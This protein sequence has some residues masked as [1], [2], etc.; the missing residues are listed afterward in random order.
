MELIGENKVDWSNNESV[1]EF[2]EKNMLYFS[3]YNL[4]ADI[5]LIVD[6]LN[7]KLAYS[8]ALL[9]KHRYTKTLPILEHIQELLQKI[10]DTDYYE[11]INENYLFYKGMTY[12]RLKN[13]KESQKCF[14]LLVNID[15]ENE[16]YKRWYLSNKNA[17]F[18]SKFTIIGYIGL[19]IIFLDLILSFGFHVRLYP[20]VVL[21]GIIM[22]LGLLMGN[23]KN[24][25]DKVRK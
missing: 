10:K 16:H 5:D 12:E 25:W 1:I 8:G 3:N 17:I 21:I 6:A 20:P 13:H 4:L 18:A 23:I 11:Q 15:P 22:V 7:T 2:Y 14:E 9:S 24:L 19:S